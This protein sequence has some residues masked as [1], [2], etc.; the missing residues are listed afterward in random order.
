MSADSWRELT[1][2]LGA[3]LLMAVAA[4]VEATATLVSRHR[5]RQLA[6]ERGGHRSVQGLLDPKRSLVAALVLVESV[7]L[8]TAASLLTTV[9]GRELGTAEHV[10]A[11]AVVAAVFLLFGQALPRALAATRPERAAVV[12]IGLARF[13]AFLVRPLTVTVDALAALIARALPG[14][15][16]PPPPVGTEEELRGLT[17]EGTDDGVIEAEEPETIDNVLHL[18]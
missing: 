6:E 7:A 15:G 8:A 2:A 3:L 12:L 9:A 1:I 14:P 11:I 18:E 10:V 16:E 13:L 17:L 5:L 4:A